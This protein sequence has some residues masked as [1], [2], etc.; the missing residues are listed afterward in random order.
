MDPQLHATLINMVLSKPTARLALGVS[1]LEAIANLR[2]IL[3]NV[4]R[5]ALEQLI[6][7]LRVDKPDEAS[8]WALDHVESKLDALY[9]IL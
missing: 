1:L 9:A 7:A 4:P 3:T 6:A 2:E 5:P 8:L